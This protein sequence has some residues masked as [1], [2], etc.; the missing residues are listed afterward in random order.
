V[1][2]T[3]RQ[4]FTLSSVFGFHHHIG[5]DVQPRSLRNWPMQCNGGEMLRP[6]HRGRDRCRP[7]HHS[8]A[9]R[10]L[11]PLGRPEADT[12]R[13]QT[14]MVRASEVVT[15]GFPLRVDVKLIRH[16]DRCLD[17]R[18]IKMWTRA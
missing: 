9:I 2:H 10:I 7:D 6:R 15:D 8:Y 1:V 12:A 17:A 5:A 16:P 18:G 11:A 4:G 3:G 14:I 13:M